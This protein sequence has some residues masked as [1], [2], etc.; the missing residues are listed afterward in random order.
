MISVL[1][2]ECEIAGAADLHRRC[3]QPVTLREFRS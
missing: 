3:C 2:S 1:R